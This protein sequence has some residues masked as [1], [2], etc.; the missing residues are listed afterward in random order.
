MYMFSVSFFKR[1]IRIVLRGREYVC[2][3]MTNFIICL[4]QTVGILTP[5][6]LAQVILPFRHQQCRL[7]NDRP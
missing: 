7:V 4:V 2:L 1:L 5:L 6:P 3:V